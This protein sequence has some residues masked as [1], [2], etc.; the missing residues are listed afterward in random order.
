METTINVTVA[1]LQSKFKYQSTEWCAAKQ[2]NIA[3]YVP[4]RPQG[5]RLELP[6]ECS[7]AD[8]MQSGSDSSATILGLGTGLGQRPI[9]C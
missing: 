4:T 3:K 1:G 6:T 7:R 8:R 5:R 9:V 2:T